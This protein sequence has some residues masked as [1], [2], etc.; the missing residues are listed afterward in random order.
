[1]VVILMLKE[2]INSKNARKIFGKK[3]IEIVLKQIEG[4]RLTQSE[5]NRLSRD[6]RPKIDF[7]KQATEFKNELDLKK[8]LE[9]LKLIENAKN[10]ILI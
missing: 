10:I 5:K 6:I 7:I 8:N 4:M 2:L 9:N 3:E 1:M